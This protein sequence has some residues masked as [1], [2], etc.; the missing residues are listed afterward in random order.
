MTRRLDF[1]Q[2]IAGMGLPTSERSASAPLVLLVQQG[3]GFQRT[4]LDDHGVLLLSLLEWWRVPR[5]MNNRY[6]SSDEWF[7]RERRDM[8]VYSRKSLDT[9]P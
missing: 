3:C 2:S 4:L 1:G 8:I 5:R 7:E 9:Q 6:S